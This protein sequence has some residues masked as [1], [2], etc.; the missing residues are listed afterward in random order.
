MKFIDKEKSLCITWVVLMIWMPFITFIFSHSAYMELGESDMQLVV[1]LSLLYT[2][3]SYLP[4]LVVFL[5]DWKDIKQYFNFNYVR[6]LVLLLGVF[7]VT[8]IVSTHTFDY[9]LIYNILNVGIIGFFEEVFFRGLLYPTMKE[10]RGR[11]LAVG[12][13]MIIFVSSH[14]YILLSNGSEVLVI[15]MFF[16]IL[17]SYVFVYLFEKT[18][19]LW[20]VILFH[21]LYDF[22]T[23]SGMLLVITIFVFYMITELRLKN[24]T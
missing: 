9:I 4:I 1:V 23:F 20:I 7:I 13:N 21:S 8:I 15:Y 3:L 19:N 5:Y 17:G 12:L 24:A 16:L 14:I 6:L 22:Q 18:G 2:V 10:K 11:G